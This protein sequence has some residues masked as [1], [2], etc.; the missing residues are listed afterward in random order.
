MAAHRETQEPDAPEGA[1]G[2][3]GLEQAE[4]RGRHLAVAAGFEVVGDLLAFAE[5]R[6][7]GALDGGDVDEG[8]LAAIIRLD[9]TEALGGVEEFHGTVGHL[10]AFVVARIEIQVRHSCPRDMRGRPRTF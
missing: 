8:V 1:P 6:K 4:V 9:E 10:Y 2:K 5:A 7:P 3:S